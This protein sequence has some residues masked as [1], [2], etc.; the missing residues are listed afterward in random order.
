[1]HTPTSKIILFSFMIFSIV[2]CSKIDKVYEWKRSDG[3]TFNMRYKIVNEKK[4]TLLNQ[5]IKNGE[6]Q[7]YISDYFSDCKYFNESNWL[8]EAVP[9][10]E[11][12]VMQ[13]GNIIWYYWAE[14]RHYKFAL[15]E[16]FAHMFF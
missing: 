13:D 1:M 11:K 3:E 8:C 6:K 9:G 7:T 16:T 4:I 15:E 5:Y 12:I 14:E 10:R 2:G